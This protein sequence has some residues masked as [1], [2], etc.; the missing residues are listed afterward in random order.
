MM[1]YRSDV[2]QG[3][4]TFSKDPPQDRNVAGSSMIGVSL[5]GKARLSTLSSV[6]PSA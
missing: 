1:P 4:S 6:Q 3:I 5:S 2:G